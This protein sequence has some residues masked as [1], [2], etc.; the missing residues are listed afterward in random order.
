MLKKVEKTA[1][2]LNEAIELAAQELNVSVSEVEYEVLRDS[3][4]GLMRFILGSEVEISAWVKAEKEKEDVK[5]AVSVKKEAS[6]KKEAPAKK[7]EV[8]IEKKEVKKP[9]VKAETVKETAKAAPQEVK[10]EAPKVKAPKKEEPEMVIPKEAIDD[11]KFFISGMLDRMGL[12]HELHVKLDR[13]EIKIVITGDKMGLLIGNHGKTL[14]SIQFLTN[15]YVNRQKKSYIKVSLDT[16]NYRKKRE[17]TLVNLAR[18][19]ARTVVKTGKTTTLEPMSANQRRIIHLTL[20]NNPKVKTYSV[21]EEPRRRV[22]VAPA[23]GF[24]PEK[25]EEVKEIKTEE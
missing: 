8:K 19:L 18:S 17:E 1:K 24:T 13:N 25:S 6:D 22:V 4:K 3:S 9:E 10:E 2:S 5:K 21:G 23:P 15:L 16:E 7:P 11:A 20:Q 12:K 14:D